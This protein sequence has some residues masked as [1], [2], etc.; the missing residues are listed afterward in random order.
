MLLSFVSPYM[1][2]GAFRLLMAALVGI[3]SLAV[4]AEATVSQSAV[5][6]DTAQTAAQLKKGTAGVV[7]K[8]QSTLQ[9]KPANEVDISEVMRRRLLA[10][11]SKSDGTKKTVRPNAAVKAVMAK[12]VAKAAVDKPDVV[13]LATGGT[14]AG[15]GA[16]EVSANYQAAQISGEALLGALP[17]L[18]RLADVRAEQI[19]NIASQ[20]M[21]VAVWQ[22]LAG[23]VRALLA[24]NDVAGLVITHGTD[25]LE[26]T[27]FFLSLVIDS[28]KPVVLT[29][30]MRPSNGLS[31]D[32][33]M[34]LYNAVAVASAPQ[35]RGRGVLVVAND[36][37]HPARAVTKTHTTR[38][39]TFQSGLGGVLG[40]AQ[41]GHVRYL[42]PASR[43][44]AGNDFAAALDKPW[45]RVDILFGHAGFAAD[46]V[47]SSVKQGAK[48]LVFAGVGNG[49][50]NKATLAAVQ[51]AIAQGVVVVR[52]S[53]VGEGYVDRNMEINDDTLGSVA[54]GNLSPAKSRILLQLALLHNMDTAAIQQAFERF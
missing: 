32:G 14:I 21:S 10:I 52:S 20:D 33:P 8:N 25:T 49:N 34:N 1:S 44:R 46:Q 37:I 6:A 17:Q 40:T 22:K 51:K 29:A 31:A 23:R 9:T 12:Q 54:A 24:D 45:P 7:V 50:M 53:R 42:R 4:Q 41:V 16:S 30:S 15:R 47:A 28:D 35:S 5:E 19:T 43:L 11:D 38:V 18:S 48:G 13:V 2:R 26:E 27:A 39:D 3:G 36:L